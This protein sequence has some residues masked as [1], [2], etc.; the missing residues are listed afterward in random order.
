M[1]IKPATG[2]HQ[3]LIDIVDDYFDSPEDKLILPISKNE[4]FRNISYKIALIMG[5]VQENYQKGVD[6][7]LELADNN[8]TPVTCSKGCY[9]C[10][11]Q[12]ITGTMPEIMLIS[13]FLQTNAETR[14]NFMERFKEWRPQV[15]PINYSANM[16]RVMTAK[17]PEEKDRIM[18]EVNQIYDKGKVV[19]CP[20]LDEGICSIYPVRPHVCMTTLTVSDPKKCMEDR[21]SDEMVMHIFSADMH[22]ADNKFARA[23]GE[24]S[25][26]MDLPFFITSVPLTVHDQIMYGMQKNIE[27]FKRKM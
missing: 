1:I 20:F 5:A 6:K 3:K 7:T 4:G 17:T 13:T 2:S 26:I 15:D 11:R 14:I 24:S 19:Y 22:I 10:C 21:T 25:R 18:L 27:F 8:G 12:P 9:Y 16:N 23:S